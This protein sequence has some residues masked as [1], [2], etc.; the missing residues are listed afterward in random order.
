MTWED[1]AIFTKSFSPKI[2]LCFIYFLWSA[3]VQKMILSLWSYLK[4]KRQFPL[5]SSCEGE[6]N[7]LSFWKC[8]RKLFQP[9][10]VV[11][12]YEEE[13]W[14]RPRAPVQKAKLEQTENIHI[15]LSKLIKSRQRR[16]QNWNWHWNQ[17][18]NWAI[19]NSDS[20]TMLKVIEK[21][22]PRHF[23]Q[24]LFPEIYWH[25]TLFAILAISICRHSRQ[26]WFTSPNISLLYIGF[27]S[28]LAKR[29]SKNCWP[30]AVVV[31]GAK[32]TWDRWERNQGKDLYV[33]IQYIFHLSQPC[34][35]IVMKIYS[36]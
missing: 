26:K 15:K 33:D 20:V 2:S 18:S 29:E 11:E 12:R 21:L 7:V 35:H 14:I 13:K 4:D 10:T 25:W 19:L 36:T 5:N 28:S 22:K 31:K 9:P 3:Y 1:L 32:R 6:T 34:C 16:G 27:L 24:L 23:W 17:F 8:D 30:L